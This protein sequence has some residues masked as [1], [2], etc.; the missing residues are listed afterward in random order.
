MTEQVLILI[1]PPGAGKSTRAAELVQQNSEAVIV[2]RD[3]LREMLFGYTEATMIQYYQKPELLTIR[4]E[5]VS[6]VQHVLVQTLLLDH[7]QVIIDDTNCRESTLF[8]W[9]LRLETY[10]RRLVFIDTPLQDC[11]LRNGLR[12]RMVPESVIHR[13]YEA[14]LKIKD[15]GFQ[16]FY[17]PNEQVKLPLSE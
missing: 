7:R 6:F 2:N 4:E 5:T 9:L 10:S 15:A 17:L 11:L 12:N 1:G 8:S 3:K 13:M 14:F 16:E